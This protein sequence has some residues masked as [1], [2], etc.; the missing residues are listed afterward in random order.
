MTRPN[1]SGEYSMAVSIFWFTFVMRISSAISLCA[2]ASNKSAFM[3]RMRR[4]SRSALSRCCLSRTAANCC[5]LPLSNA[6]ASSGFLSFSSDSRCG[7]DRNILRIVS[8]LSSSS[9]T[10]LCL[11]DAWP[12][13]GWLALP[14]RGMCMELQSISISPPARVA[15]NVPNSAPLDFPWLII[16]L[17]YKTGDF[18]ISNSKHS[19]TIFHLPG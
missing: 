19:K 15:E 13:L 18:T 11:A 3:V 4:N 9:A 1:D 16:R 5:R 8:G 12:C 17:S 6:S 14:P 7:S 10:C 2:S